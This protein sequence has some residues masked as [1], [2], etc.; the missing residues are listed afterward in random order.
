M[1][2]PR[3]T[4]VK[5]TA[6]HSKNM[7]VGG[8][9]SAQGCRNAARRDPFYIPNLQTLRLR[10]FQ[11]RKKTYIRYANKCRMVEKC[12]EFPRSLEVQGA[13]TFLEMIGNFYPTLIQEFYSNFQYREGFYLSMVRGKLITLDEE[14]LEV[15][16]G[17]TF[18]E[19]I[20][21]FYPTFIQE[22]Y[23]NFQYRE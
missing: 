8:F 10:M 22:F 20:G 16:G 21:N 4:R 12:F 2:K 6:K 3:R 23:S 1:S 15:Q 7:D 13:N 18:L 19:M 11:G 17:N 9:S 5:I 14:I